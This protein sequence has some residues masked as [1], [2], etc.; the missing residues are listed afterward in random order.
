MFIITGVHHI[1]A[2][3]HTPDFLLLD[4]KIWFITPGS[5]IEDR[6]IGVFLYCV[7]VF[8]KASGK[9]ISKLKVTSIYL[10]GS[11]YQVVYSPHV[12][13]VQRQHPKNLQLH[14]PLAPNAQYSMG[15]RITWKLISQ[16]LSQ[17]CPNRTASYLKAA[18]QLFYKAYLWCQLTF[19]V[20]LTFGVSANLLNEFI[21][22]GTEHNI[23][24]LN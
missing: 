8:S 9:S 14:K 17:V 12:F 22:C 2:L 10:E 16:L 21:H 13:T 1:K 19:G 20:K 15:W 5:S 7:S 6:H 24:K 11:I 3:F 4:W 23:H 18:T